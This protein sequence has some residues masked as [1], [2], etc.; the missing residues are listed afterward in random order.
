MHY[1]LAAAP[2][3]GTEVKLEILDE[4][5]SVL[6]SYGRKP[7]GYDKLDGAHKAMDPGPWLPLQ[8]G[9]NT[10]IWNL[11]LPGATKVLGNKTA[12]EAAEGPYVLPGQYQVR[13]SIGGAVQV[14]PFE[15]VNDPRADV[16]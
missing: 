11:R 15:V 14:Q 4:G 8:A 2:D 10:F 7:V 5:G 6:R 12:G 3:D 9:M 1:Y 13:L 16:A